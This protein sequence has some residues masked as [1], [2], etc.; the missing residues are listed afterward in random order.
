MINDGANF[1]TETENQRIFRS[2]N[3]EQRVAGISGHVIFPFRDLC[4]C[5]LKAFR[6]NL[7]GKTGINFSVLFTALANSIKVSSRSVLCTRNVHNRISHEL[8]EF[9]RIDDERSRFTYADAVIYSEGMF[10]EIK[11]ELAERQT[12]RPVFA[13]VFNLLVVH[14]VLTAD[15]SLQRKTTGEK[16]VR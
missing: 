8:H 6:F 15:K 13:A 5:N 9:H 14:F 11:N 10:F 4:S 12:F 2:A 16:K 3:F 1:W 7:K